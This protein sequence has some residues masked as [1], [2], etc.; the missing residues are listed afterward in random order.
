M[1]PRDVV[2]ALADAWEKLPD[3]GQAPASVEHGGEPRSQFLRNL[4]T[5]D[6]VRTTPWRSAVFTVRR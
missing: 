2:E 3:K 5:G 4:F 6:V 1:T